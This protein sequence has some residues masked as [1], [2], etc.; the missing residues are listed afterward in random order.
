MRAKSVIVLV[1]ILL[2]ITN[3]YSQ[4]NK[5]KESVII[6]KNSNKSVEGVSIS[7]K[8][9][10]SSGQS[11]PFATVSLGNEEKNTTSDE[12]GNFSFHNVK[13]GNYTLKVSAMG[14]SSLVKQIT[15][16]DKN[17]NLS[18]KLES[19]LNEL[20]SVTVIGRSAVNQINKQAY[21]VTAIDAKKL[22][23][24]TL[25][26]A[27][28]LDRVSGVRFREAGGVGSRNELSI[29]GFSGNQI[30]VFIDGVPMDNFG[31]SFQ[32]NNIPINLADRV[33]VYKGVVPI[34]LG[35][36]ALGGAVNIVTN[37]KPRTYF[38]ASYSFG[39]FNTHKSAINAG[40]TSKSGFTAEI[41]AFQNYSDNNYWINVET[42]DLE[43]GQYYPKTRV[44]RFHD[45]YHNE[46]VIANIGI[47]GKKYADKLMIGFTAG[48][49]KADIQTGAR[50]V[51]VF[52]ERYTRGNTLMPTL[53]YQ[54][55]DLFTK[56]LN[57]NVTGNFNFGYE[58]TVDTVNRRYNW[59][60]QYTQNQGDGGEAGRSLNKMKNN[61]GVA[62][63]NATYA[64]GERHSFLLNNTFNTFDRKQSDE[65]FP[66]SVT[67]QQ[68]QKTQK[69]ILAAG[70][71]FDYNEKWSTSVFLKD[72][73]LK[74]TYTKSYNPSGNWGD[75]AYMNFNDNRSYLG[76]GAASSYYVKQ[77]L[78]LKASYEKTYRLPT[79]IEIFGNV[80]ENIQGNTDL[81]PESSN[82][83]N[84][85][86]SYQTSFNTVNALS[87]DING[88]YRKSTD[89]I[90]SEFNN[91]QNRLVTVNQDAVTTKGIDGEIRYS[92]KKRFTSGIN[93]TYQDI[94]NMNKYQPEQNYV[95]DIY[96]DRMPNIPYLF[97]NLDATLFYNDVFKKGNNLSVGYN[98][99]YVHG[100]YLYWPARG[101]AYGKHDIPVQLKHD[102][103][104]VY[105]M[106]NGKYNL[107][108]ECQN[109]MD[110]ELVDNF[111]LPKP[112]RAFYIK[113]RYFFNK[114]K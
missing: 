57:V 93:M 22:H 98:L 77:N 26:L 55:K 86:F 111:S 80:N 83:F 52:G 29:N 84:L 46:T 23:N 69:N 85:G 65:L 45:T 51:T 34:W 58:Q 10:E 60:G 79:P 62:T 113:F 53:K 44:R 28:A 101:I 78:Q 35:G 13:P 8:L 14:F 64:L 88:I 76:Y 114:S 9:Q 27:H 70:Y 48:Q 39:S 95:S 40:Y 112:G 103:N 89:F 105:T 11:I 110:N 1:A 20:N 6:S 30:K 32:L 104:I 73:N 49:N 54:V 82:N 25:D 37:S 12:N 7:G 94:R 63:F 18:F 71:K 68:P 15:V 92:Y 2:T 75:V 106:A 61:N 16:V 47:T 17:L 66:E 90:R 38:D 31:S 50:L 107:A 81:I 4:T 24:S 41:N 102:L 108:L 3:I 33:E 43:T 59:F 42:N 67:Y 96:K 100:Y 72:Y 109:L 91:N 19:E 99:L 97:G 36:D 74:T 5:V 56:G 21:N 87:F